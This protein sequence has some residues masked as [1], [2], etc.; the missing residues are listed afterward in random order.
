MKCKTTDMVLSY[1]VPLWF[2]HLLGF[3]LGGENE[4]SPEGS[5]RAL[6][7]GLLGVPNRVEDVVEERLHLLEEEGGRAHGQLPQ[8]EHLT[9]KGEKDYSQQQKNHFTVQGHVNKRL[10][11]LENSPDQC[12]N[13][14]YQN[15]ALDDQRDNP[16]DCNID[17]TNTP[18]ACSLKQV[19][20]ISQGSL[21]LVSSV[22][23]RNE[24]QASLASPSCGLL[25]A[26]W[27]L[28][29]FLSAPSHSSALFTS[30]S[31]YSAVKV[32]PAM[33]R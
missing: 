27:R 4:A 13:P 17:K 33:D 24:P 12:E 15:K 19:H 31:T 32:S 3:P 26:A 5:H 18:G 10:S 20:Q 7:D 8:D 28:P 1:F 22:A 16:R 6:T 21:S 14:P 29:S 11:G 2:L 25:T 23:L 30:N 9:G